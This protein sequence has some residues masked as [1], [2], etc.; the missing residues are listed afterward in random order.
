MFVSRRFLGAMVGNHG[1]IDLLHLPLREAL[2]MALKCRKPLKL[3]KDLLLTKF[4]G[5]I[6]I[7][8]GGSW[9]SHR[10]SER[11]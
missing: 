3:L 7:V 11:R 2:E 10:S 1:G 5:I 4:T 6:L 9:R 8:T